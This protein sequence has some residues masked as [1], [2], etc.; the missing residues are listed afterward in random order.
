MSQR[1]VRRLEQLQLSVA[2]HMEVAA[3]FRESTPVHR[4]SQGDLALSCPACS[5]NLIQ[6]LSHQPNR[7][8]GGIALRCS[9]GAWSCIP[10]GTPWSVTPEM[11]EAK[12]IHHLYRYFES[13]AYRDEFLQGAVWTTTLLACKDHP[14]DV[15]ADSGEGT[16]SYSHDP[17]RGRASDPRV[18]AV[19]RRLGLE[20]GS[21]DGLVELRGNSAS[22]TSADAWMLCVS[23]V[24]SPRLLQK[25]GR[26][27]VRI[28]R[29]ATLFLAMTEAIQREVSVS[30]GGY[31][32]VYYRTRSVR[33]LDDEPASTTFVKPESYADESETRFVW[34]VDH[35][36]IGP[37]TFKTKLPDGVLTPVPD[38]HAD[39][40]PGGKASVGSSFRDE[41]RIWRAAQKRSRKARGR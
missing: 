20:I 35:R 9:C 6:G 16:L 15:R 13:P 39:G 2:E 38:F 37:R 21:G 22:R 36:E 40:W 24:Y 25:F 27:C 14:D 30:R 8:F 29:P 12:S 3:T 34:F 11:P 31:R 19:A 5:S 32:R 28:E 1:V 33:N 7:L 17:I 23:L 41:H 26:Y 10:S 4:F 18:R